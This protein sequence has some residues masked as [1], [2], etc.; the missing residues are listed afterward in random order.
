MGNSMAITIKI[1]TI[2]TIYDPA[3]SLLNTQT[4]KTESRISKRYLPTQV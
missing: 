2:T 1:K 3:I 4:K